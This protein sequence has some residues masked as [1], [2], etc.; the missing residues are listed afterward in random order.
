VL[1]QWG[2]NT[3]PLLWLLILSMILSGCQT[4]SGWVN[5]DPA[6]ASNSSVDPRLLQDQ[7]EF[8][9]ESGAQ[10]CMIGAGLGMLACLMVRPEDRAACMAVAGVAGCGI[11][12]SANY[13]LDKRRSEYANREQRMQVY[14]ADVQADS[15]LLGR[16]MSTYK[17]VLADDSKELARI[18]KEIQAKTGDQKQR[19]AQLAQV[20]NNKSLMEQ[21]L[22]DLNK[23]IDLYREIPQEEGTGDAQGR[24]FVSALQ[25]LESER[26]DLQRLL[27]KTYSDLPSI[28]ASAGRT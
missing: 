26:D 10:A 4:T 2:L 6:N 12:A 3:W 16:R 15:E 18:K 7:P 28:V 9:S 27:E 8:F 24:A 1:R 23:K 17:A 5:S 14:I 25:E 22:A 11:G 21:E 19:Q 20:M 13:V